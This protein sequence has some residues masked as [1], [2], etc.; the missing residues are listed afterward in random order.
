V[1][2]GVEERENEGGYGG[3]VLYL[4]MKTEKFHR[5]HSSKKGGEGRMTE[6]VNPTKINLKHICKYHNV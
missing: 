1:G 2:R 6:G 3:C 5:F 4:Y